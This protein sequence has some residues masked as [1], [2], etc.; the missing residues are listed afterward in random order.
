MGRDFYG[1]ANN[2]PQAAWPGDARVAVS[3]VLNIEEGAELLK[4]DFPEAVM[5]AQI[6]AAAQRVEHYEMAAYG[7][8]AA[9]AD[10]LGQ[11]EVADLLRT[12]NLWRVFESFASEDEAVKSFR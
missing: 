1:Y 4:E 5:D 2:P 3:F 10:Q 8:V 11:N 7:T 6:I 12:V 9:W